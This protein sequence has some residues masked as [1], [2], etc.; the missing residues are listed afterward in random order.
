MDLK[1][2]PSP[3]GRLKRQL[4]LVDAITIGLG[5][6]IGADIFVAS[7]LRLASLVLLC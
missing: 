4:G 7:V 2:N 3:S 5:A 1:N 6:V